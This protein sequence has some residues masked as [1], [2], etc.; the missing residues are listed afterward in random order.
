MAL[1]VETP[2]FGP[3]TNQYAG[4]GQPAVTLA[5][6]ADICRLFEGIGFDGITTTVFFL[7]ALSAD[8][9]VSGNSGPAGAS[10]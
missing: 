6:I 7:Q 10:K 9:S 4:Q 3:D 2:V 1:L 8:F 5:Q